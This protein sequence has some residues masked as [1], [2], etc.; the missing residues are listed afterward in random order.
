MALKGI[1]VSKHQGK[2]NWNKVDVDFAIIRAGY[3]KYTKQKD[4]QFDNNM[5]GALSK[6]IPVGVYWYSYAT[7]VADAEKEAEVCLEVIKP[8]KG[9]ITLPVFFDQEY[10]PGI[11]KLNNVARTEICKAFISKVVAA[12][13]K[14]GLYASADWFRNKVFS[15]KLID[16]PAWVAQYSS[17]CS[18][19]GRN[20][21]MWQYSS[22]GKVNGISGNVDLD[23]GYFNIT[24]TNVKSVAELAK[25]VI[26]GKWGNGVD[27]KQRLTAAGYDYNA[28]QKEVNKLLS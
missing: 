8:Y 23:Y 18:Y 6:K 14:S 15:D 2:I 13:Y 1:D 24:S 7:T 3:G 17:K 10:E 16:Y 21:Y 27:R 19:T 28:V 4:S 22:K 9:K 25:E 26:A 11:L 5:K 20:L 12:G